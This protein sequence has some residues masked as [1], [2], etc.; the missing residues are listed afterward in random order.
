MSYQS[1]RTVMRPLTEK[2]IAETEKILTS[3]MCGCIT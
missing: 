2:D 3:L 1:T